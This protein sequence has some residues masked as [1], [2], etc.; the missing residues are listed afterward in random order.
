MVDTIDIEHE[1]AM[2][3]SIEKTSIICTI[4]YLSGR[5]DHEQRAHSGEVFQRKY[6][7]K[8]FLYIGEVFWLINIVLLMTGALNTCGRYVVN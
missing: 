6:S 7:F 1:C 8:L 3:E 4:V 5:E 2:E